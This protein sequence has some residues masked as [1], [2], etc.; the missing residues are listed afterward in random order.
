M[1]EYLDEEVDS[2]KHAF[3]VICKTAQFTVGTIAASA[4]DS[5]S[6]ARFLN[7]QNP[8]QV[9]RNVLPSVL[10]LPVTIVPRTVGAVLT[11]GGSAAAQGIAMLNPQRWGGG[12]APN[13]SG[14]ARQVGQLDKNAGMLFE[15]GDDDD[16]GQ[17]PSLTEK[18]PRQ[19]KE[20]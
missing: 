4:A 7:S 19:V 2:I 9:K 15:I 6:T 20:I 12:A 16:E 10:L 8:A 11:T 14:Y 5:A 3:E 18:E 17:N 13:G 1:D